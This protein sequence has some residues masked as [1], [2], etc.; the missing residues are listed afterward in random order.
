M[1]ATVKESRVLAFRRHPPQIGMSTEH[2]R[3]ILAFIVFMFDPGPVNR[4][5]PGPDADR[6]LVARLAGTA[7]RHAR[8]R[9]PTETETIAAAAGLRA[10]AGDR[11]G[12]LAEMAGIMLGASEGELGE[13]RS[14]A[15]AELCIAAG[16]GESPI[17]G[18]IQEG[19]RRVQS[20]P[21][22]PLS[23]PP[24]AQAAGASVCS[25]AGV[26][27]SNARSSFFAFVTS[28]SP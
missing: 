27:S 21:R 14:K 20:R 9:E 24:G 5:R 13:P 8:W 28:R 18:W 15:A 6:L 7:R 26:A 17:P 23:K 25:G 22:P 10:I 19:R 11:A 4:D 16:A 12:L 1:L 2:R 3:G